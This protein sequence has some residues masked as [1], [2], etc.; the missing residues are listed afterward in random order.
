VCPCL[1]SFVAAT[2]IPALAALADFV[3]PHLRS[4]LVALVTEFA[5]GLVMDLSRSSLVEE[6][7]SPRLLPNVH[8]IPHVDGLTAPAIQ[9]HTRLMK[10]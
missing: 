3:V 6:T 5:L 9:G 8:E 7:G 4:G 2:G 10:P 1:P